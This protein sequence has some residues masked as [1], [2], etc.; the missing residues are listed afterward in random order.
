MNEPAITDSVFT[1]AQLKSFYSNATEVI[2]SASSSGIQVMIHGLSCP[3]CSDTQRTY[4]LLYSRRIL[5][6]QLLAKLRSALVQRVCLALLPRSR[7]PSLLRIRTVQQSTGEHDSRSRLQ[8]LSSSEEQ[9]VRHHIVI[10]R[11]VESR[12]W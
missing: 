8:L 11:R 2:R 1:M 10:R 9:S 4:T 12:D 6:T 3:T 7:R 5:G